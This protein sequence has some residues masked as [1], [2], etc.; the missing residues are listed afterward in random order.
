MWEPK[1]QEPVLGSQL[2]NTCSLILQEESRLWG[3]GSIL[4]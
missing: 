3:G 4:F 2:D 1:A